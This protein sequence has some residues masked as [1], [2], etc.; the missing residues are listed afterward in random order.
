MPGPQVDVS[1]THG[2]GVADLVPLAQHPGTVL[3]VGNDGFAVTRPEDA[4]PRIENEKT[5]PFTCAARNPA[6]GDIALGDKEAFVKVYDASTGD[7]KSIATRLTLPVRSL[8][9]S[10]DGNTLAAAGDGEGIK[11]LNTEDGRVLRVL[12]TGPQVRDVA[13]DPESQF[14]ASVTC[15]GTIQVWDVT[16]GKAVFTV[17]RGAPV[18]DHFSSERARLAW[19]PDGSL[20][21]VPGVEND[22]VLYERLS[23]QATGHLSNGH[24]KPI[25]CVSISPNGLYAVT[26]GRD[27]AVIL[28]D[29]AKCEEVERHELQ[30][31]VTA[32]VWRA[33]ANVVE[34]IDG[35]G[36]YMCWKDAVPDGHCSPFI[37]LDEIDKIA[38]REMD[39]ISPVVAASDAEEEGLENFIEEDPEDSVLD[40]K[41]MRQSI[42]SE[43]KKAIQVM[44][45]GGH[46][47]DPIQQGCT[48]FQEGKG[49]K[50]FLTY[51]MDGF[52]TSRQDE[53][54][55]TVEVGFHDVNN[56]RRRLPVY[57]DFFG[58]HLASLGERG[59]AY[60]SHSNS[61][62]PSTIMYRPFDFWAP[63]SDWT[64]SLP[65]DEEA[66]CIVAG[67]QFVA[68][69]TSQRML[70]VMS[71]AGLHLAIIALQGPPIALAAHGNELAVVWHAGNAVDGEQ[72]LAYMILD[73]SQ[74]CELASGCVPLAGA[75]LVWFG[76]SKDGRLGAFDSSEILRIR[77]PD[78]GGSWTPVFTSATERK[79]NEAYFMV[80]L[81][82][83]EIYCIVCNAGSAP[84]VAP[85][86]VLSM[87]PY[88]IPI[89]SVDVSAN[90]M[91][92]ELLASNLQLS[93]VRRNV[94]DS[95]TETLA[96]E[97]ALAA[98]RCALKLFQHALKAEL[99]GKA[100]ELACQMHLQPSIE[101]AL[102]LASHH[103]QGALA[104]RISVYLESRQA[105]EL[106][107]ADDDFE[108][109]V[110]DHG[111][112]VLRDAGNNL[113]SADA[114]KRKL[115]SYPGGNRTGVWFHDTTLVVK[116]NAQFM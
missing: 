8:S 103:H 84:Q 62:F 97:T 31:A 65:Q 109:D 108:E 59:T 19:H 3:T 25:N 33:D 55:S 34:M 21:A 63:K 14:V 1:H 76:Y 102:R 39:N 66:E 72:M 101:G 64:I 12:Q 80:G 54:G 44:K 5:A 30:S 38:D 77:T 56:S 107:D 13:F 48:T 106:Q 79:G 70:R 110:E 23:W 52:I 89:A 100:L 16:N 20:L 47:Q 73:V 71:L 36:Q 112:G 111:A 26:A 43:V 37:S 22:V 78:F 57:A 105:L 85:K 88:D 50:R 90:Q 6:T 40:S 4:G 46:I 96:S 115:P 11:L 9:Y 18:T 15:G 67:L 49:S 51:T 99:L 92:R 58:F 29:T 116:H 114:E 53:Y 2:P 68:V 10:K 74:R 87:L 42:K 61:E 60:A 28:W 86:P 17:K 98:D 94:T 41:R 104:E 24:S 69:A 113:R 45:S 27:K 82:H 7:F 81:S 91:E 83:K 35:E 93:C 95:H 75:D 32:V